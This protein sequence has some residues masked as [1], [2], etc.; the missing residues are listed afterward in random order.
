MKPLR[1]LISQ[2]KVGGGSFTPDEL[3]S[4]MVD[5]D[6]LQTLEITRMTPAIVVAS[7]GAFNDKEKDIANLKDIEVW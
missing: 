2:N 6:A 3:S 7:S 5:G 1:A 4:F